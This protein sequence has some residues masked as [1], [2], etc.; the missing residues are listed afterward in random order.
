MMV[1]ELKHQRR[2]HPSSIAVMAREM[3]VFEATAITIKT[4]ASKNILKTQ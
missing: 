2:M 1:K 3:V 4:F